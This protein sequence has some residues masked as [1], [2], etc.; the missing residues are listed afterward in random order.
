MGKFNSLIMVLF[1]V[2][3]LHSTSASAQTDL[4]DINAIQQI[5]LFFTQ[6]D[7]DYEL[8]TAKI[9]ADSYIMA[10]LVIVN[11]VSFDS[12]GVKYKGN[13]SYNA[14][15]VKNPLHI[16]LNEFKGQSYQGFK[17]IKLSNC[18]VDPSMIREVLA[19]SVLGNYM[20]CSKSNF[21][22][23]FI[24]GVYVGLYSNDENVGTKFL[25]DKF[26]SSSN[27]FIKCNPIVNPGPTTKCN[28]KYITGADSSG[29]FNYY[30]LKSTYGWNELVRLCDTVTNHAASVESAMDIDR[31]LWMLAFNNVLINLDSYTGAFAQ[32]YYLYRDNNNR[33]APIVWDLN[34]AL[35]G[36]PFVG[37]G[38]SSLGS[39][40]VSNMQ[41][42]PL[43]I[44]NTDPYWPLLNDLN[45]NP[46][47]KKMYVAHMKTILNE[48]FVSNNYVTLAIQY[49][50][51]V[52]AAVQADTNKAFTYTQFQN[53]LNSNTTVGSY[54]VP[55]IVTLMNSRTIYLQS[56]SEF[57][58]SAPAISGVAYAPSSPFIGDTVWVTATVSNSS[59][60]LVGH[61]E[62]QLFKF[63]KE[64]MYDDGLHHDGVSGDGVYGTGLIVSAPYIQYYVYAENA[65]AAMFSPV[66]A[67]HEFYTINANVQI[68]GFHQLAINEFMA[69]NDGNVTD[70]DGEY[71]DWLEVYNSTTS[72]I[73]LGNVYLSNNFIDIKKWRFPSTTTIAASNVLVIWMDQDTTQ[74]GLHANFKLSASGD[75]IYIFNSLGGVID[76][77]TFGPQSSDISMFRCP[78]G[79]GPFAYTL[80]TTFNQKN[81]TT[82]LLEAE[83]VSMFSMYP[84]PTSN[85][86][87]IEAN[88]QISYIQIFDIH[89]AEVLKATVS[90]THSL[91]I[92][93]NEL[94]KGIYQ[95]VLN[96]GELTG[97]LMI[98]K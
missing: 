69:K 78:D 50:T 58:A 81:C 87:H 79:S 51:L 86:L 30:D 38:N 71:D 8:D 76:S 41:Q 60:V 3:M 75:A 4:Y 39:L 65:A 13:S 24:N 91:T 54:Q 97:K 49:Q 92:I 55:G 33:F 74:N 32:N 11:G 5:E 63:T 62:D 14:S 73:N 10:S 16:S 43:S 95:V 56:T 88:S 53:S 85:Q 29:Y 40:T 72:S 31:I 64:S 67:E 46:Q 57:L 68:I 44:H 6:P 9:G 42:L 23:V 47:W 45:N 94:N 84:N 22:K 61:R 12:V 1:S 27:T 66:R 77:L 17:D 19:Y 37:S 35:G 34:M 70:Q 25:T 89:G 21:A 26:S 59:N 90:P 82:G 15:S 28:L 96:N 48:F 93:V 2:F 83:K 7:W 20:D 52:D 36:F 18:Y 98:Y 80:N